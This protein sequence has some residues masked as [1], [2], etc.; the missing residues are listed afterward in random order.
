MKKERKVFIT[1]NYRNY[2]L[3]FLSFLN[4]NNNHNKMTQI[5]LH[6]ISPKYLGQFLETKLIVITFYNDVII[7]S[8]YYIQ[9]PAVLGWIRVGYASKIILIRNAKASKLLQKEKEKKM[10]SLIRY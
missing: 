3:S 1:R 6:I 9:T 10:L 4:N 5:T 8:W 7:S 2:Y